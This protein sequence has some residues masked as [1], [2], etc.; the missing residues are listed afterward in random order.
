[1][2]QNLHVFQKNMSNGFFVVACTKKTNN[3][4]IIR[5]P[6]KRASSGF[7]RVNELIS[8]T[9]AK[10]LNRIFTYIFIM[11][12]MRYFATKKLNK[13][14]LNLKKLKIYFTFN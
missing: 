7:V 5:P 10:C 14:K 3:R 1:M 4:L 6:E 12:D 13:P 9:V 11:S 2:R 8:S